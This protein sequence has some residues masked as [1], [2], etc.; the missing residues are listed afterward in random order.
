LLAI[1]ALTVP[2]L[3]GCGDDEPDAVDGPIEIGAIDY[4]FTGVPER[5]RVGATIAMTNESDKEVHEIIAIRLPDDEDRAVA[6]I[7]KLPEEELGVLFAGLETVVVAPPKSAG[8]PV[9]GTG[10]LTKPGRYALICLIPT[11]ADPDEYLAA[12]AAAGGPPDVA[13]GPPHVAQGMFA[14]LTVVE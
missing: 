13:G 1:A 6:D 9:E 3:G 10:A 5:A 8:F 11:G 12:A 14:E 7:V 4:S 2:L